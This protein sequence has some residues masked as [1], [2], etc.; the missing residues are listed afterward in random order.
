MNNSAVESQKY[1]VPHGSPW[2]LIGSIG[3]LI[4]M[5]G[6]A[7]WLHLRWF[8]PYLFFTGML[9]LLIMMLGWFGTVIRENRR[10]LY[11]DQVD[12]TFRWAMGWFIFSEVAFFGAF[13]GALFYSKF[14][15]VP[16]LGGE[17]GHMIATHISLWPDFSATWPLL[18]NPDNAQFAG[19]AGVIPAFGLPLLNTLILLTS[20]ATITW[21]HWALKLNKRKQL[22]IGLALTVLLGIAFL[23]LQAHEY[24]EAY[25]DFNLTLQSGIYGSTFFMLTG[26]H[27]AHVTVGTIILIVILLRCLAGHFSKHNHFAFEAAAWYWHF[28][29]VV[30]LFLFVLVYWL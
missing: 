2:P 26:F 25:E 24:I 7:N 21:A 12:R 9:V 1:Y 30:W 10:G 29:D 17:Y 20:G 16:L 22:I 27:G 14:W 3:L 28:V 19:A 8:G 23:Y 4:T 13:F 18:S 6:F 15:V 5:V 11:N